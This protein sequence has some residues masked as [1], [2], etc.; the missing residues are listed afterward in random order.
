MTS[1]NNYQFY[2][3]SYNNEKRCNNMKKRFNKLDLSCI[4]YTGV[5]FEDMR[6]KNFEIDEATKQIWSC[7][8]GH[9][10]MINNFY[11]NDKYV[12]KNLTNSERDRNRTCVVN[13]LFTGWN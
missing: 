4:F 6:I 3:L 9:L 2:C 11:H 5:N 7:M 1:E 8:Y 13:N 12:D 10:D